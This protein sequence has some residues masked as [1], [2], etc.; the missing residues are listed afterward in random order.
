M[1]H[2]VHK[3]GWT[4]CAD[5]DPHY[6]VTAGDL[7]TQLQLLGAGAGFLSY[8]DAL[9]GA[10]SAGGGTELVLT[11]D[12]GYR[13]TLEAARE[14]AEPLGIEAVVF[15]TANRI[16]RPGY[17]SGPDLRMLR[18]LG[19]VVGAHGLTHRP[20][21]LLPADELDTELLQARQIIEDHLGEQVVH[22][23]LPHGKGGKRERIQAVRAGYRSLATSRVGR[24]DPGRDERMWI[25]RVAV[26][27][28][29]STER[30]LEL[31]TNWHRAAGRLIG[32]QAVL[33][34][35]RRLMGPSLYEKVRSLLLGRG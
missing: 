9:H 30:P 31:A 10:S 28:S 2:H 11:F 15:V 1:Y 3:T 24:F 22:I 7:Q 6:T 20:L 34:T 4:P 35:A 13:S 33:D 16:G 27:G 23:S 32:R 19:W 21:S 8:E 26:L 29:W 18:E 5:A 14:L 12:D 17:L 25:P